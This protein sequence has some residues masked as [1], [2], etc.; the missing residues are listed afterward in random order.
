M[1]RIGNPGSCGTSC[2]TLTESG[3]ISRSINSLERS[4]VFHV[5]FET[6]LFQ[7]RSDLPLWSTLLGN[8]SRLF[9]FFL[10]TGTIDE[11]SAGKNEILGSRSGT[12]F[13]YHHWKN[14]EEIRTSFFEVDVGRFLSIKVWDR[15]TLN[16][17]KNLQKGVLLFLAAIWTRTFIMIGDS[18]GSISRSKRPGHKD[19][20]DKAEGC[21]RLQKLSRLW[22]R[23]F[24]A[25]IQ[26]CLGR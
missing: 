26:L 12:V 22:S 10:Q 11:R 21:Q 20:K 25:F 18:Y 5:L 16:I 3:T 24:K 15:E 14:N 1:W 8:R 6:Q 9:H 2:P 4:R 13:D 7:R 19:G 23:N 17:V